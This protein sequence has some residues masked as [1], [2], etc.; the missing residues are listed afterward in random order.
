MYAVGARG[1]VHKLQFNGKQEGCVAR[2]TTPHLRCPRNGQAD[3]LVSSS[4]SVNMPLVALNKRLGRRQRQSPPSPDTGQQGGSAPENAL[5]ERPSTVGEGGEDAQLVG[6]F[7]KNCLIR[8]RGFALALHVLALSLLAGR[9]HSLELN[10]V[11]ISATRL[12]QPLSEVLSSVSVITR[13]DIEKSQSPSLADL[14]QGEA[15]FEFGRN[16]GPGS[17]TSFFLRGQNSINVVLLIDGVRSQVDGIGSLQVSD[18]PLAQ[19]ERIEILRGNTSALYGDAA[20]GGV[21]N[22]WTRQGRGEPAAY[23]SVTLGS[24]NTFGTNAGL[25]GTVNDLSFNVQGGRNGSDGFSAMNP[26][27]NRLANPDK[28]GYSNEHVS[29]KLDQKIDADFNVGLRLQSVR[30]QANFDSGNAYAGDKPTDIHLLN[31]RNDQATVY[32]RKA[33]TA[34]WVSTLDLSHASLGYENKKNS[35]LLNDGTL[36]GIQDALRWGNSVHVRT[37]SSLSFGLDKSTD[38]YN[39]SGDYGYG[40][41]RE[42]LGYYA[43]WTEKIDRLTL[44]LNARRDQIQ[45]NQTYDNTVPRNDQS[46]NSGLMGVG[47]ALTP[48]WRVTAT[49]S[50]G[51]RAPT[52]YEISTNTQVKSENYVSKEMGA[53]YATG[54]A[55]ARVVYF[56]T[57]TRDAIDY[58][59]DY[60][61]VNIGQTENKGLE[62]TLQSQWMGTNIKASVVDQNPRNV[63][64][65]MPQARRAKTYGSIDISRPVAGFDI[66]AKL[67]ASGERKDSPYSSAMLGGYSVW[68]FYASRKIDDNWTARVRLEN[69]FDKQYQL[70]YGYNTP[71]R[72]VFASLQYSPK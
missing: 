12:E 51:F 57:Q 10:P 34:D 19:I 1:L 72:G 36:K 31:S 7:M 60:R 64:L 13:Q 26:A 15:G 30:S 44:Q 28:D 47:Y 65:A 8:S 38:Q 63:T 41:R 5:L 67:Y 25:G 39:A 35:T 49:V 48:A 27:M 43:G 32:A 62:A 14:L 59:S 29:A 61:A 21:I 3:E 54:N 53:S 71:G 68:S 6:L 52:A 42:G 45:L 58:D 23:G 2:S 66:G 16:G 9:A 50:T 69:I 4:V 33:I 46:I 17:T 56:Q 55:L 20:V 11:V 37:Q 40:M 24:R 70:A 18:M 22:I